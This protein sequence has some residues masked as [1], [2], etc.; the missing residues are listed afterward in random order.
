MMI[1]MEVR[2][3]WLHFRYK[4]VTPPDNRWGNKLSNGSWTGML[5]QVLRKVGRERGKRDG[6]CY[7]SRYVCLQSR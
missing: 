1:V 3:C 4:L 2:T 5:G 7:E 6:R